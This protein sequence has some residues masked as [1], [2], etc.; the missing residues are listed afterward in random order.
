[1]DKIPTPVSYSF[2]QNSHI[3]Y[4]LGSHQMPSNE[5]FIPHCPAFHLGSV[6]ASESHPLLSLQDQAWRHTCKS[7]NHAIP[8][9]LQMI[10]VLHQDLRSHPS[11]TKTHL[12]FHCSQLSYYQQ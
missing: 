5:F 2:S 12:C 8:N 4:Q 9:R 11:P 10:Q 1:M 7:R 3:Y 6:L